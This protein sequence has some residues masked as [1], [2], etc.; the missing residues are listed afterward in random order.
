MS[1]KLLKLIE[2]NF[3]IAWKSKL[4][5]LLILLGPLLLTLMLGWA[6]NNSKDYAIK[7]GVYSENYDGVK[8]DILEHLGKNFVL[9]KFESLNGCVNS[10][11]GYETHICVVMPKEIKLEGDELS[12]VVFY[13]DNSRVNLVWVVLDSLSNVFSLPPLNSTKPFL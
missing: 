11:K 3:K 10:V 8:K 1:R 9:V 12:E 5:V 2:K 13:A 7:V 6:F 4:F